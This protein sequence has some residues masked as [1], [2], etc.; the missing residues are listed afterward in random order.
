L[1]EGDVKSEIN[2]VRQILFNELGLTREFVRETVR[3]VVQ[4]T[5]QK[6]FRDGYFEKWLRNQIDSELRTYHYGSAEL[7]AH[8]ASAVGEGIRREVM[9]SLNV[10][11]TATVG[12]KPQYVSVRDVSEPLNTE[13]AADQPQPLDSPT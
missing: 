9:S 1:W 10:K 2:Q 3:D 4:D 12:G 6:Y 11:L 8:I 13:G 5:V 7:K